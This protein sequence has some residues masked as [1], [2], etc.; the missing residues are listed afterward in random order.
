MA[1][2]HRQKIFISVDIE[3]V[4]SVVHWNETE[5]GK[6]DYEFFRKVMTAETN[7]A[8]EAAF[9]HGASDVFVRDAHG[10]ALNIL[11]DALHKDAKL[12]RNWGNTPFCMME[13]L[14]KSFY[15]TLL[16]GYHAKAGTPN[17]TLKHTMHLGISDVRMN[18]VSLAESG[19]NALISGHF[20]VPVIFLSGDRAISDYTSQLIPNIETVTVKEGLGGACITVHPDVSVKNIKAGVSRAL[21]KRDM[22]VPFKMQPPYRMEIQFRDEPRAFKASWYPGMT[23][24]DEY[25]VAFQSKSLMDCLRCFFFIGG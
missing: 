22:I 2:K 12:I 11:P 4:T 7:A 5:Q 3:G 13:G 15:A 24:L 21:N 18:G 17:A 6:Q 23:R 16:I 25:T 9:D 8:I 1:K 20:N 14:D 19:I 10:S